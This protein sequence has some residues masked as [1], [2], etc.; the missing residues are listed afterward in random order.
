MPFRFST[1]LLR[2]LLSISLSLSFSCFDGLIIVATVSCRVAHLQISPGLIES[3]GS[4]GENSKTRGG[5][6]INLGETS[7]SGWSLYQAE[8]SLDWLPFQRGN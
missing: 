1:R 6:L 2:P 8:I 5:F 4:L 7:G 3:R